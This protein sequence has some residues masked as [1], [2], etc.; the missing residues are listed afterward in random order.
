MKNKTESNNY[1]NWILTDRQICDLELI[2]DGSFKPLSGF[3]NEVD[4]NNVLYYGE[5][6]CENGDEDKKTTKLLKQFHEGLNLYE[7]VVFHS[8]IF[9]Q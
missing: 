2:I 3:L 9:E 6:I 5:L 1:K 8:M 4:Y 7:L